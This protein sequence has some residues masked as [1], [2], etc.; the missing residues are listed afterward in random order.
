MPNSKHLTYGIS[1]LVS[2]I[3]KTKLGLSH[4]QTFGALMDAA[5]TME[6]LLRD[7]Y[8]EH[9]R[10]WSSGGPSRHPQ[11]QKM[12]VVRRVPYHS[13]GGHPYHHEQQ[14]HQAPSTV[15]RAPVQQSQQQS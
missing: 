1:N 7:S 3:T 15:Y 13:T 6:G 5:I 12:Q 2:L 9:K 8:A 14:S 4:Y 11:A 10:K